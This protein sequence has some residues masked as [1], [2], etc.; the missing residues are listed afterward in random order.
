MTDV[1]EYMYTERKQANKNKDKRC[2]IRTVLGVI[3]CNCRVS[4][5]NFRSTIVERRFSEHLSVTGS[6]ALIRDTCGVCEKT[7]RF[8]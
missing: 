4:E 5:N 2:K 7:A 1:R 8:S 6:K 3:R